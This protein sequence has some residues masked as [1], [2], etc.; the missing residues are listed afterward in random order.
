MQIE[1]AAQ[2]YVEY[3]VPGIKVFLMFM[4][5]MFVLAF[6]A[7]A[8]EGKLIDMAGAIFEGTIHYTYQFFYYTG[9]GI[10]MFFVTIFR[11]IR[12]VMAIIR[13]FFMSRI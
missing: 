4:L 9:L 3:I 1:Q 12:I 11:G 10:W 8:K 6:W 5:V 13:D 7:K 2:F